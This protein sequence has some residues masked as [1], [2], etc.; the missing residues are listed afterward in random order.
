MFKVCKRCLQPC[1]L[2]QK[3]NYDRT[4]STSKYIQK[5]DPSPP[6]PP[7]GGGQQLQRNINLI[8]RDLNVKKVAPSLLFLFFYISQGISF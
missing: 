7:Q 4:V 5:V 3:K 6:N 2:R 1:S 8:L